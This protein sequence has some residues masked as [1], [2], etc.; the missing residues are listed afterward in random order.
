MDKTGE[1]GGESVIRIRPI[2]NLV[3]TTSSPLDFLKEDSHEKGDFLRRTSLLGD[4]FSQELRQDS[5][6]LPE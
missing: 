1:I 6:F 4:C 2:L 5:S 3:M